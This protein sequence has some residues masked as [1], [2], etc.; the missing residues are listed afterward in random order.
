MEGGKRK[1]THRRDP[2]QR[3]AEGAKE[4]VAED[5]IQAGRGYNGNGRRKTGFSRCSKTTGF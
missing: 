5:L 3:D 4:N 1:K 2:P